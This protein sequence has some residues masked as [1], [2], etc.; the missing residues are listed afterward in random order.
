[1]CLALVLFKA[2]CKYKGPV[3]LLSGN[4]VVKG[5]IR[6]PGLGLNNSYKNFNWEICKVKCVE[7]NSASTK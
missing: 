4:L 2:Y 7:V 5:R 6:N 1:M 3:C